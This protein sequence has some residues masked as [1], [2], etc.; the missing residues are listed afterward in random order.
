MNILADLCIS[1][2][3]ISKSLFPHK[4]QKS[5]FGQTYQSQISLYLYAS[6]YC[7]WKNTLN[8][9]QIPD[10]N[11]N[12]LNYI[13]MHVDTAALDWRVWNIKFKRETILL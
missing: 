6:Q 10:I 13:D 8:N 2:W 4:E 11:T 7:V 5:V 12:V 3:H 9:I 1:G